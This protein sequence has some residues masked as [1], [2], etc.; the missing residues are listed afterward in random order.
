MIKIGVVVPVYNVEKYL[1]KC[2]ESIINQTYKNLEII[3]VNDGSTDESGC[4]CDKYA[5]LD[6][7]IKVIHQKNL[8]PAYARYEGVSLA[9]SD[10]ITFVDADDWLDIKTYETVAKYLED[11]VDMVAFG[12]IRYRED[13]FKIYEKNNIDANDYQHRAIQE[14]IIPTMLW[15]ADLHACGI[16]ASLWSKVAKKYLWLEQLEKVKDLQIHYGEDV[17]V[18]YP[19]IRNMH[20]IVIIEHCF[21]YHRQRENGKYP[22]YLT[23]DNFY[24]NLLKLYDYLRDSFKDRPQLLRQLEYFY[25]HAIE[26]R[27][28]IYGERRVRKTYTFPFDLIEKNST[29]VLYG[30]G[31]VGQEFYRQVKQISYCNILLWV[32]KCFELYKNYEVKDPSEI[33]SI[34]I[35]DYVVIANACEPIAKEIKTYL[36][37]MGIEEDKIIWSVKSTGGK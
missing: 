19:M 33:Q 26:M 12:L 22:S 16:D 36:C 10:Y 6:K 28:R 15:D 23:T 7:R 35:F 24:K 11:D 5:G 17:A 14:K 31:A 30:A 20:H 18:I 21:Y 3:L 2:I 1:S 27:L 34:E 13:G 25:L 9:E 4:I 29:I 8:G 32:D 37:D